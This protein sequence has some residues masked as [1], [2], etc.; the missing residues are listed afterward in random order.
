MTSGFT[1]LVVTKHSRVYSRL[2]YIFRAEIENG[3][4]VFMSPSCCWINYLNAISHILEYFLNHYELIRIGWYLVA[5]TVWWLGYGLGYLRLLVTLPAVVQIFLFLFATVP[6]AATAQP[7]LQS[8]GLQ[9]EKDL[10]CGWQ[11]IV[12]QCGQENPT[13]CHFLYSLFFF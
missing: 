7:S 2:W 6:T 11:C 9:M 5:Q 10:I 13:R 4:S 3:C 8:A 1:R 12:I